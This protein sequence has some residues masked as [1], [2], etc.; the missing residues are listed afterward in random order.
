MFYIASTNAPQAK[1]H[2]TDTQE[3][4]GKKEVEDQTK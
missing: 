2:R 3:G 4:G 1:C